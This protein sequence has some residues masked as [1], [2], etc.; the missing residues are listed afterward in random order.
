MHLGLRA[1]HEFVADEYQFL[2]QQFLRAESQARSALGCAWSMPVSAPGVTVPASRGSGHGHDNLRFVEFI[3]N[4]S[5]PL[6]FTEVEVHDA[7]AQ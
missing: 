1:L 6:R 5:S 7:R 4:N 2:Q 3:A